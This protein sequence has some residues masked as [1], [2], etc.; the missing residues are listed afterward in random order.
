MYAPDPPSII[1]RAGLANITFHSESKT[2]TL[3]NNDPE[4]L[5][6]VLSKMLEL[7]VQKY[8]STHFVKEFGTYL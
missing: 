4:R 1:S 8:Y 2:S 5:Y 6:P 7:P 3:I